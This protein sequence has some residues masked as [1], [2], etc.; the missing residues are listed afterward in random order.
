M[1][2]IKLNDPEGPNT[3]AGT[4]IPGTGTVSPAHHPVLVPLLRTEN[5]SV[6]RFH[7][8]DFPTFDVKDDLLPWINRCE[9][10]FRGQWTMEEEKV[11]L[12]SYH[13]T[14]SAQQWYCRLER[15]EGT[16]SWR[17]FSD[18]VNVRFGPPLRHNPLAELVQLKRT[19][20]VDDFIDQFLASL[21]RVRPLTS[22]EQVQ[23]FTARLQE[24]LSIDVDLQVPQTMETT[25]SLARVYEGRATVVAELGASCFLAKSTRDEN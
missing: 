14:G 12:A 11:R 24:P 22:E 18:L 4:G 16:P 13:L 3:G 7:K 8:L 20:T 2:K 9:Q 21:S 17:R 6:L 25:M 10:F 19:G 15:E 23:L 1:E 5:T